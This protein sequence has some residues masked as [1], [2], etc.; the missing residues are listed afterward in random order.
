MRNLGL[1][2]HL[3]FRQVGRNNEG[4]PDGKLYQMWGVGQSRFGGK[5][6]VTHGAG[7]SHE[8]T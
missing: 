4:I 1:E 6:E 8:N 3:D 5:Q 7:V 2:G